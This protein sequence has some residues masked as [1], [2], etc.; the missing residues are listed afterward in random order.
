MNRREYGLA[1]EV[2][3]LHW[4]ASSHDFGGYQPLDAGVARKEQV[5]LLVLG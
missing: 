3:S 4:T 5:M 2:P 1:C